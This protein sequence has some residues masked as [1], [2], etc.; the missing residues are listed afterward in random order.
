V[1]VTG[2]VDAAGAIGSSAIR[3]VKEMMVGVV[4]GV[5][6]VAGASLPKPKAE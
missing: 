1:V 4:E 5:K 3:T 6:D 2:A